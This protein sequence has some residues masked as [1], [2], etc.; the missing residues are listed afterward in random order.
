MNKFSEILAKIEEY[1]KI[2]IHRH[3]SRIQMRLDHR[4]GL[5]LYYGMLFHRNRS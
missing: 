3:Q 2:I 4:A 5:R 1:D